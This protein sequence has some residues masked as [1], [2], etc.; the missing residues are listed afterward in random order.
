MNELALVG[1]IPSQGDFL[2][3]GSTSSVVRHFDAWLQTAMDSLVLANSSLCD[4]L[5]RFV[6]C[7]A[8]DADIAVGLAVPSRDAAGRKYPLAAMLILPR[9]DIQG[10]WATVP[11]ACQEF[12]EPLESV[13]SS[14]ARRSPRDVLNTLGRLPTIDTRALDRA[15]SRCHEMFHAELVQTFEARIFE[16]P[17]LRYYAYRTLL[18]ACDRARERDISER[19]PV[20]SCSARGDLDRLIWMELVSRLC[21]VAASAFWRTSR[22]ERS[23]GDESLVIAFSNPSHEVWSALMHPDQA[24]DHVWSLQTQYRRA[25][26]E[27]LTAIGA[28]LKPPATSTPMSTLVRDLTSVQLAGGYRH[29]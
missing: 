14:V 28:D 7:P 25:I 18:L 16:R 10:R 15:E 3:V 2:R 27:A 26:D 23:T 13:L 24:F 17:E 6:F 19:A 22:G 12:L 4:S 29:G 11:I 20:L 9:R 1:K 21:P 8:W 5:V